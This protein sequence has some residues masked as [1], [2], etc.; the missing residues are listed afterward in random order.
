MKNSIPIWG[1][2]LIFRSGAW[3]VKG[4][5]EATLREGPYV[6]IPKV[7]FEKVLRA[8]RQKWWER[9]LGKMVWQ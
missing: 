9:L 1:V 5:D 2:D 8:A 4:V 6:L 3:V 7:G